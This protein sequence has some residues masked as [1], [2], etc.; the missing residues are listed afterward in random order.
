MPNTIERIELARVSVPFEI[1]GPRNGLRPGLAPWTRMEALIVR[2]HF[3]DGACG[4]GEAFGHFSNAGTAAILENLVAPWFIGKDGSAIATV[5][6]QAE[7]AFYGFGRNGPVRYALSAIDIALWD[8]AA[9][10]A[11]LPLYR[12][13]GGNRQEIQRYA[14][15]ARYG[16]DTDVVAANTAKAA[17]AGFAMIKLHESTLP[18]FLAARAAAGDRARVALDVNCPWTV[19]EART[20]ARRIAAEDFEWLEEPVWPPEDYDGMARLRQEGV[21]IAAGENVTTLHDFKRLFEARAVDVVQPS[22][23]KAGGIT[24]MRKVYALAES[25]T[26]R[27]APHCYFWGP[28]YLATAHLIAADPRSML[29][30][31]PYITLQ[32]P[33]VNPAF[34]ARSGKM[35]LPSVPGLGFVPDEA[36]LARHTVWSAVVA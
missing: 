20:M 11:G 18:A 14:S 34:D 10:R 23:I 32:A 25:Y 26:V 17:E 1:D 31:T 12:L 3:R 16:G 22:V 21:P 29:L 4:W 7:R 35:T 9:Q 15:F 27:V 33:A 28:G 19:E 5:M 36:A 24:A 30:E 8:V 6:D 2:V 13:L